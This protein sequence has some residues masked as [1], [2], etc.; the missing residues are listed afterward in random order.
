MEI[1]HRGSDRLEN[2]AGDPRVLGELNS[3]V[4]LHLLSPHHR[5]QLRLYQHRSTAL[6]CSDIR[7]RCDFNRFL[8][9]AIRSTPNT[10]ALHYY[11]FLGRGL[12][13]HRTSG[14]PPSEISGSHVRNPLHHPSG[15]LSSNHRRHQLGRQ[16]PLTHLEAVGRNGKSHLHTIDSYHRN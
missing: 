14:H 16:Q 5:L 3:L 15:C 6:D 2:L 1:Y 7:R 8:F 4:R 9:L 13:L 11:S 12:W 10:L